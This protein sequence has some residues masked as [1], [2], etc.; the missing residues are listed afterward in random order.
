MKSLELREFTWLAWECTAKDL[1]VRTWTQVWLPIPLS[2]HRTL[3]SDSRA[4]NSW[5]S[6]MRLTPL[7]Q[8]A[9]I[10]SRWLLFMYGIEIVFLFI[11]CTLPGNQRKCSAKQG[12]KANGGAWKGGNHPNLCWFILNEAVQGTQKDSTLGLKSC[13]KQRLDKRGSRKYV[14]SFPRF[15]F[16]ALMRSKS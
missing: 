3:L 10:M 9:V 8:C 4:R 5:F 6:N 15:G 13:N 12:C 1:G 16:L 11:V 2:F 14:H 7:F